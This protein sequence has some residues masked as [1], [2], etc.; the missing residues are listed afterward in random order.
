MV[1]AISTPTSGHLETPHNV[2]YVS[3]REK[4]EGC[5][6]YIISGNTTLTSG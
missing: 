2:E 4:Q 3:E 1:P 5:D 6:Y